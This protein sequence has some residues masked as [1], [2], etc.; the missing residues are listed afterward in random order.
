MGKLFMTFKKESSHKIRPIFWKKK[1]LKK[2]STLSQIH[3]NSS[4]ITKKNS[5]EKK[6]LKKPFGPR[7]TS[8]RKRN[9]PICKSLFAC[10]GALKLKEF[11]LK[12]KEKS[13]KKNQFQIKRYP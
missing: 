12:I 10:S 7:K 13:C 5:G 2:T 9:S 3:K 1:S 11:W 4:E 8:K 6:Q